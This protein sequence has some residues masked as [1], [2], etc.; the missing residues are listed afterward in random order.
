[1]LVDLGYTLTDNPND[2]T[3]GIDGIFGSKTWKA[4][5]DFQGKN[6]LKQ[7]GVVGEITMEALEKAVSNAGFNVKVTASLLNVRSNPGIENAIVGIVRKNATYKL[8]EIKD[9]WGR[10]ASPA[11]W[12]SLSYVIAI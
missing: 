1:M 6:N 10:I 11:G 8:L 2:K 5:I 9:G 4:I 3:K 12:I 7:D